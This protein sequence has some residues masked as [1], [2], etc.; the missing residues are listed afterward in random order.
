MLRTLGH[1]LRSFKGIDTSGMTVEE[2][3]RHYYR[4]RNEALNNNFYAEAVTAIGVAM[5][6]CVVVLKGSEALLRL[7]I[8]Y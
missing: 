4:L 2:R 1:Y 5:I 7:L 8:Q 3:E 6:V